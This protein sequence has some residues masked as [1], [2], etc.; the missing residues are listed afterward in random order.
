MWVSFI[1][2]LLEFERSKELLHPESTQATRDNSYG[3]EIATTAEVFIY[4]GEIAAV[5][6]VF[7][8]REDFVARWRS[9]QQLSVE[10][11]IHQVLEQGDNQV[12]GG[13][14]DQEGY[15]KIK[16]RITQDSTS[17]WLVFFNLSRVKVDQV[18]ARD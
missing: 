6:E 14:V 7:N 16:P 1:F 10:E 8:Y 4:G 15:P 17:D 11:Q 13:W 12:R 18:T 5:A 2:K 9:E 3:G